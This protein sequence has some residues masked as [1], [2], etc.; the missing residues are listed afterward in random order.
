MC[1]KPTCGKGFRTEAAQ[2]SHEREHKFERRQCDDCDDGKWY[3]TPR[4]WNRHKSTYHSTKWDPVMICSVEGCTH[5]DVPFKTQIS[6]QMHLRDTHR[7]SAQGVAR[8]VPVSAARAFTWGKR[9]C[10]F[11]DCSRETTRKQYIEAHLEKNAKNEG[12]GLSDEEVARKMRGC[13]MK[14]SHK[15]CSSKAHI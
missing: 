8:Y 14:F 7:L 2:K 1:K 5:G 11:D 13:G 6:Y 12:H 3:A 10:P 15:S 9:K 4:Q